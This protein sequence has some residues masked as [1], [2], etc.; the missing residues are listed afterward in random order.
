M[1]NVL[2][3]DDESIVRMMLHSMIDWEGQ[4]LNL[5]ACAANGREALEWMDKCRIDIL[6]SL[7]HI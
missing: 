2:I 3:V 5:V 6:L 7:I 4:E 1:Y